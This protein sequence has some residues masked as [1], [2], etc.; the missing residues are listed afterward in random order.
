MT[1]AA[2]RTSLLTLGAGL[3]AAGACVCA[4][5]FDLQEPYSKG[6]YL[7][8]IGALACCLLV[9]ALAQILAEE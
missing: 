2:F 9:L 1:Y 8:L 6:A 5:A 3:L 7:L 4:L